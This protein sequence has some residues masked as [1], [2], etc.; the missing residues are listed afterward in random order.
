VHQPERDGEPAG[1]RSAEVRGATAAWPEVVGDEDRE[2]IGREI[3]GGHVGTSLVVASRR[4]TDRALACLAARAY[5][6]WTPKL[7]RRG[8][9]CQDAPV[10]VFAVHWKDG[11]MSYEIH[12]I[13]CAIDFSDTS[14]EA[15]EHA[16]ALAEKHGASL[17]LVH[18]WQLPAYALPEGAIIAD[19]QY[20]GRIETELQKSLDE[21][22]ARFAGGPVSVSA[23]LSE[24]PAHLEVIR[25]AEEQKVDLVVI[26]THGRTGLSHVLLGSVAERVVR[27]SPVPVLTVRHKA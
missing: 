11:T 2:A 1:E 16:Y 12:R 8:R 6:T 15:L 4:G 18:A 27:T 22:V 23:K 7:A 21:V 10:R 24:G 20:L 14:K 5:M 13:L 19:S 17:V 26:G 9:A 3:R 25:V